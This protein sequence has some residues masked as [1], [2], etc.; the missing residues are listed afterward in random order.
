M[1]RNLASV[2]WMPCVVLAACATDPAADYADETEMSAYQLA[3]IEQRYTEFLAKEG[4]AEL[5]SD[6]SITPVTG[7]LDFRS[8][9]NAARDM[10]ATLRPAARH[11]VEHS[12]NFARQVGRFRVVDGN[13]FWW[14]MDFAGLE[15]HPVEDWPQVA[16]FDVTATLDGEPVTYRA[17]VFRRASGY[18]HIVDPVLD[19]Q[20][21]MQ[22]TATTQI[23]RLE[24]Q[25]GRTA[26]A[27]DGC[28]D[29][30]AT[31]GWIHNRVQVDCIVDWW[32]DSTLRW[33]VDWDLAGTADCFQVGTGTNARCEVQNPLATTTLRAKRFYY[34]G[35]LVPNSFGNGYFCDYWGSDKVYYKAEFDKDDVED[36]YYNNT[37][38]PPNGYGA[39][40][41]WAGGLRVF[42]QNGPWGT[43]AEEEKIAWLPL[44]QGTAAGTTILYHAIRFVHWVLSTPDAPPKLIDSEALPV[45]GMYACGCPVQN[46]AVACATPVPDEP[47]PLPDPG[48]TPDPLPEPLPEPVFPEL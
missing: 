1:L 24:L 36:V 35:E 34:D 19:V 28:A 48:P 43:A 18:T 14:P 40:M 2:A 30:N 4:I 16:F 38:S 41:A 42:G 39:H 27:A 45:E 32:W 7:F 3:A 37:V 31:N 25:P 21:L 22:V 46:G 33:E 11:L 8:P 10:I 6:V 26:D 5:V 13:P 17:L 20:P 47:T 9:S 44:L 23:D 12:E 29:I 15:R